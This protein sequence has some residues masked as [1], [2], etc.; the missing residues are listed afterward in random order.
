MLSTKSREV[1]VEEC[2]NDIPSDIDETYDRALDSINRLSKMDKALAYK[3]L[4]WV[5]YAARQL[6]ADELRHLVALPHDEKQWGSKVEPYQIEEILN[7]C[8]HLLVR[9]GSM[10]RMVHYSAKEYIFDKDRHRIHRDW[11]QKLQQQETA[12]DYIVSC[13]LSWILWPDLEEPCEKL[14]DLIGRVEENGALWHAAKYF[15]TYVSKATGN[16]SGGSLQLLERLL[17]QDHAHL[18]AVIQLRYLRDPFDLETLAAD[19]HP[20]ETPITTASLLFATHLYGVAE[21]NHHRHRLYDR[22]IPPQTM[23]LAAAEGLLGAV[24][25]I[26]QARHG[27]NERDAKGATPLYYAAKNG[28]LNVCSTLLRAG[29]SADAQLNAESHFDCPL[30]I[31]SEEGQYRVVD[32]LLKS[33][34]DV[35]I[36][37]KSF[38][39]RFNAQRHFRSTRVN[40]VVFSFLFSAL[41]FSNMTYRRSISHT[42]DCSMRQRE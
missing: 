36:L 42:H 41:I 2:L 11:I 5:L 23:H 31:A 16:L 19:F 6:R 34:A 17:E 3:C 14:P 9:E 1:D 27:P 24:E 10:V 38:R 32:L 15:D 18:R 26:L 22:G 7:V 12:L 37:G 40:L 30:H 29:A 28:H 4:A 39:S 21:V 35:S 33:G 20:S 13:S 8:S 25:E